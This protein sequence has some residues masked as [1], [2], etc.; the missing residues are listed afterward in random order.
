VIGAVLLSL[1]C[2]DLVLRVER[3]GGFTRAIGGR[4]RTVESAV[5][6]LRVRGD[7]TP[8]ILSGKLLIGYEH[9]AF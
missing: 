8:G 5:E 9:D 1:R 6:V 4:V 3:V 2:V 7:D